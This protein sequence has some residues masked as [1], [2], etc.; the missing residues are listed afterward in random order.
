M[1]RPALLLLVFA[2]LS[3]CDQLGLN[4]A[5]NAETEGKAI[6]AACR[7]S[8]RALEDCYQ[9]NPSV[10]KAAIFFGWKEMN[11]YMTEQKIE[12]VKPMLPPQLPKTLKDKKS[13]SAES[14][15]AESAS[16]QTDSKDDDAKDSKDSS[17]KEGA[18]DAEKSTGKA[19]SST[20][21]KH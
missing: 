3:G 16:T 14:S 18:S 5:K 4:D 20:E 11:N 21:S 1:L 7:H 2:A 15:D 19:N 17:S 6:G 9:L 10:P 8:G 12:I 13:D